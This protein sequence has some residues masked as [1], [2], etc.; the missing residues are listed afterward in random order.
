MSA[1][2]PDI[3]TPKVLTFLAKQ[4]GLA[5][6]LWTDIEFRGALG[7]LV[8]QGLIDSQQADRVLKRYQLDRQQNVYYL[9]EITPK[10]FQGALDSFGLFLS[11]LKSAD[12]LH[13]GIARVEGL[14]LV[15]LD[16]KQAKSAKHNGVGCVML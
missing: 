7:V 16:E 11:P 8:R 1:Y 9:I 5:L 6:S 15:T 3:H 13:V 4:K 10:H 14:K 12:A 2:L